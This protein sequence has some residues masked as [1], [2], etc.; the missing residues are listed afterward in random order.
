MPVTGQDLANIIEELAPRRLAEDWDN[1]GWQIGDP[2]AAVQRVLLAL[3]VDSAVVKEAKEKQVNLIISHHPLFMKGVKSIRMD[4]PKGA[5]VIELIK[6]NIGVYAAHTNLDSAA[7][8]VNAVLANR[9]NLKDIEILHPSGVEKYNKLVVFVPVAEADDVS[10]AITQAGAGWIGNYSDCTF[11][12]Q[13]TGTFRPLAGTNPFIGQQG[14]LEQVEEIRLETIVPVSKV[15]AVIKAMLKAHP[16]EEV[17]YDLYPLDNRVHT[18]GLGRL[19]ML[20]EAKSFADLVIQVKEALGVASVRVGGSM[21]KDVRRV[22]VCGGSAADMWPL[23]AAKGA[24]VFIT[25]DV[26][27]HTAQDMIAAGLNFIDA[28]HFATEYLIV[29]ALQDMLV[30]ACQEKNLAVEFMVTKRQSD[31]FMVL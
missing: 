30:A 9:L 12:V 1:C 26:K 11:R 27:Y 4:E 20:P 23:A 3:D 10:R 8:G 22:A 14:Q 6:N 24:D 18:Q 16:Y 29:P 28:G 7:A 13:G 21:W 25:G 5:L 15:S 2:R 19:G 17:A 31:P